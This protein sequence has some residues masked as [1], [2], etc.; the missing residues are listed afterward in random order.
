MEGTSPIIDV[1]RF[2]D[3]QRFSPYQWGILAVCFLLIAI[4]AYDALTVGFVVP[5]LMQGWQ[6]DKA[7]FGPVM[8][9]SIVGMAVGA[10]IS[11]PLYDRSTPKTVMVVSMVMFGLCSFGSI[12]SET[13]LSLG[14]WRLLT[15]LGIGAAV[16]GVNTLMFEYAPTRRSS[17]V[18]NTIACGGMLGAAACGVA[19]G[20]L[21]P[22]YGWK[23]LFVVGAVLPI[24]LALVVHFYMPE[25]LRFMVMR[26]WPAERIAA[27][28]RR[29][30][31]RHDFNGARFVV[32]EEQA[33]DRKSGMGVLLSRRLRT[34]T[35]MLWLAYFSGT[36]AYYL[37]MGWLPTLLQEAGASLRNAT[38]ATSVL[39]VGGIAGA[40]CFGWL[41]DRLDR[42][43]V[44]ALAF[45][46]G[47]ASIW[48]LGRQAGQPELLPVI[49]FIA[50]AGLSGAMFSLPGLAA[51]YYPTN[52]R[53]AGIA[54]MYGIGRIG[55]ILG[56]VAGGMLLHA[57]GSAGFYAV[58]TAT[59]LL[60]GFALWIKR[61]A[62]S[63]N[64]GADGVGVM[65]DA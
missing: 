42:N 20:L 34:G 38:L 39:S 59:I 37:L 51:A 65:R 31:P 25:P 43:T 57:T 16:P 12:F 56:P 40:L 21:V 36:F 4:D 5:A 28:L 26:N 32:T 14:I 10:M 18:I 47:G 13:P 35:L 24:V 49:L 3:E 60:P 58:A 8:S 6:M 53:S 27:V 15:G 33:E 50:G 61:R 62:A 45:V 48:T 52:G 19:A 29:V 41:M 11:G 30:A 63:R 7:V 64:A 23:C 44:I 54:W 1:K 22:T 55:G 46:V 9:A 17:L 2:I